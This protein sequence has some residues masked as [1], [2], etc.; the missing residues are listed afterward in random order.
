[1]LGISSA[2]HGGGLSV[3]YPPLDQMI[4]PRFEHG[5]RTTEV[6]MKAGLRGSLPVRVGK[7]RTQRRITAPSSAAILR[8]VANTGNRSCRA[9]LTSGMAYRAISC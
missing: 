8:P 5:S 9:S 7:G 1:M 4:A 6:G 3:H 2:L